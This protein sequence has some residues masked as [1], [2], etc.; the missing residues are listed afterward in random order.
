MLDNIQQFI[1]V[2]RVSKRKTKE[3]IN[4]KRRK[5]LEERCGVV[6][7]HRRPHLLTKSHLYSFLWI[8]Q[9][10]KNKKMPYPLLIE[11]KKIKN[12]K[13]EKQRELV[14]WKI[15]PTILTWSIC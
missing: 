14:G 7:T 12:K 13:E 4:R 10:Q 8:S 11:L 3:N 6:A 15:H 5:H 1:K 2:Y 9:A